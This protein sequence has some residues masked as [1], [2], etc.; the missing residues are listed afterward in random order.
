MRKI[1]IWIISVLLFG[2]PAVSSATLVMSVDYGLDGQQVQS[3]YTGVS[4][5]LAAGT[6]INTV[7]GVQ[8]ALTGVGASGFGFRDRSPD[9]T[10]PIGDLLEDFYFATSRIELAFTGLAAG[11]YEI[12][13]WH[14]DAGYIQSILKVQVNGTDLLNGVAATTGSNGTSPAP[15]KSTVSFYSD[16]LGADNVFYIETQNTRQNTDTAVILNGFT[17]STVPEPASLA[18]VGLGLAGLGIPDL[19]R[20]TALGQRLD[21][22]KQ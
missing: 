7:G 15:S 1:G 5:A 6:S 9:V 16:G 8:V 10:G 3:G 12:T 2:L 19:V 18:L 17:L 13:A 14:H 11:Q 20:P 22:G 4:G 21:H